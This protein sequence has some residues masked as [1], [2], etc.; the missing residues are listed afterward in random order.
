MWS[1]KHIYFVIIFFLCFR[2][3]NLLRITGGDTEIF[4][5]KQDGCSDFEMNKNDTMWIKV[6][7]GGAA[8]QMHQVKVMLEDGQEYS[9]YFRPSQDETFPLKIQAKDPK[10]GMYLNYKQVK[11]NTRNTEYIKN[12]K[13]DLRLSGNNHISCRTNPLPWPLKNGTTALTD[14]KFLGTCYTFDLFEIRDRDLEVRFTGPKDSEFVVTRIGLQST[15]PQIQAAEWKMMRG[16][17]EGLNA[18]SWVPLYY[19]EG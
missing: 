11:T 17:K 16:V 10:L 2:A 1:H 18:N 12:T 7:T 15:E 8:I 19:D 14:L 13:V 9:A 4:M 3:Y 6:Q 5:D